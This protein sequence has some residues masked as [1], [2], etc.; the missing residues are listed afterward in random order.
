MP[1]A[2]MLDAGP[3]G[4]ISHPRPGNE[5]ATIWLT[6][7]IA[8]GREILIP[9][10]ADFEVRRELLRAGL[11]GGLRRLDELKT[12]L[13]YVPITT[14]VMLKAAE[15]WAEARRHGHPTTSD[16]ALD[17]D[18]ILAAQAWLWSGRTVVASTN[19]RHLKRFVRA[20]HWRD[21]S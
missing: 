21:I 9:E 13:V 3:L 8:S 6:Q 17:A 1:D 12:S 4:M 20:D 7:L 11:R 2:V 5:A 14:D 18:V 15:F 10:I 19:T 16:H